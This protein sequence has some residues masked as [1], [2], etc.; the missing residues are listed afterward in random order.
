MST[1]TPDDRPGGD[2]CE[3]EGEAP[4]SGHVYHPIR[5]DDLVWLAREVWSI[6]DTD[7]RREFV[8]GLIGHDLSTVHLPDGS[9]IEWALDGGPTM[10]EYD[11]M[12]AMDYQEM[13]DAGQ[14]DD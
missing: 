13:R 1:R 12:D 2:F 11:H 7:Q 14:L 10:S 4:A 6:M 5:A 3:I 9:P 8:E